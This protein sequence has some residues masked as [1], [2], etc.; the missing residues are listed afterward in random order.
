[1]LH[2]HWEGRGGI[3]VQAE[4]RNEG[5]DWRKPPPPVPIPMLG[6][7][8]GTETQKAPLQRLGLYSA[9]RDP[10][11][12][13]GSFLSPVGYSGSHFSAAGCQEA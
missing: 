6:S 2:G 11:K 10:K 3:S 8:A 12:T 5:W 1:M 4:E 7:E 9:K 13:S